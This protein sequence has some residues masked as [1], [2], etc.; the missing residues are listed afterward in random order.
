MA[1]RKMAARWNWRSTSTWR[2]GSSSAMC[3]SRAAASCSSAARGGGRSARGV[4]EQLVQQ[5]RMR[6]DLRRQEFAQRRELDE[7]ATHLRIFIQQ[8]EVSRARADRFEHLAARAAAR[9]TCVGGW[10]RGPDRRWQTSRRGSRV[11]SRARPGA[12]S[13]RNA[14]PS[15]NSMS[16]AAAWSASRKPRAPSAAAN[17]GASAPRTHASTMPLTPGMSGNAASL[18]ANMTSWKARVTRARCSVELGGAGLPS[19]AKPMAKAIRARVSESVRQRM[20]LLV[21]EH[22]Q[23]VLEAPQEYVGGLELLRDPRGQQLAA[24]ELRQHRQQRRGLHAAGPGRR[25]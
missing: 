17:C 13:R 8:R 16:S 22:L 20:G 11:S 15:R 19:R 14:P 25:E 1:M 7:L 23:P 2:S 5:Q 9:P 21:G 6:G 24:R 10:L 12:S 3:A 18:R 4:I